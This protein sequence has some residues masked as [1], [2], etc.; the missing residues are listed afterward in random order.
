MSH[1]KSKLTLVLV[2]GLAATA[3]LL[4]TLSA[5]G[6][7]AAPPAASHIADSSPG[8]TMRPAQVGSVPCSSSSNT[9]EE[10]TSCI[11]DYM[12]HRYNGDGG[13][14]RDGFDVPTITETLQWR[15]VVTQMMAGECEAI[16]LSAYDWGSDFAVTLFTDTQDHIPYCVFMETRYETYTTTPVITRVTHGWGTFIYNPAYR[17]ELNISAPHARYETNTGVE[18]IG[19]FKNTRSRTF[20]MTGAHRYAS[21]VDSS[22]QSAYKRSDAVHNTDHMFYAAIAELVDYYDSRDSGFYHLQFHGMAS[23]CDECDVYLSHGSD[24]APKAGDR[25]LEL[26]DN[27]LVYH[28]GWRIGVS[29]DGTCDLNGADNVPG[30][31]LNK[32]SGDQVCETPASDYSGYFVHIE[33]CADYRAPDDWFPAI[34]ETWALLDIAK[35]AAPSPVQAGARLTYTLLVTNTSAIALSVAITDILPGH[36]LSGT[37]SGGTLI[38]PGGTLTWTTN[39]APGGV[40]THTVVVTVETG[41]A[42]ELTNIALAAAGDGITG[43]AS[44]TVCVNACNVYLPLVLRSYPAADLSVA[45]IDNPDPVV[46]GNPLTYVLSVNNAGPSAATGVQLTDN[47]PAGVTF[48]AAT[49]SQG[50]CG[51]ADGAVTCSLG[52]IASGSNATATIEVTVG[53]TTIG[54]LNN[55]ADVTGNPTD[56]APDNNTGAETTTVNAEVNVTGIMCRV[57]VEDTTPD[58]IWLHQRHIDA[59]FAPLGLTPPFDARVR[60]ICPA[61]GQ[62]CGAWVSYPVD[63]FKNS[64]GMRDWQVCDV[65]MK[66]TIRRALCAGDPNCDLDE[67]VYIEPPEQRPPRTLRFIIEGE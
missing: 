6:A 14:G 57:A 35:H 58:K 62:L 60:P 5:L 66:K 47:L 21:D 41:Y 16:S 45:K 34:H 37:T 64:I 18:A 39:I 9:L 44:V 32:V 25:I 22:C 54:I 51:Y 11:L 17:R 4:S 65:A 23:C 29:G 53:P 59:Y 52:D 20:L 46:A 61:T 8:L 30:R 13:D 24:E 15:E 10:L 12:P 49:P 26:R 55:R 1:T 40:W 43:K 48:V 27:L 33:Q 28:P 2:V 19:I 7:R 38:L 50:S 67:I 31:L 3:I 56:P 42:G 36:I 63:S